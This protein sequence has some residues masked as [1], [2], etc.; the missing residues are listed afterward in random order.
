MELNKVWFQ[1]NNMKSIQMNGTK[2]KDIDLSNSDISDI[3]TGIEELEGAIVSHMQV[4]E[5]A[6]LLG[7][8][9]KQ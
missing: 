7:L 3:W 1:D 4:I 8:V 9:I 6:N 2:L 5:F